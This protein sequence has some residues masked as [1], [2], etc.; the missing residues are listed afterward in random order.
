MFAP[1]LENIVAYFV[2]DFHYKR[3]F[4]FA[5]DWWGA[6]GGE[7]EGAPQTE[8]RLYS[9]QHPQTT[10]VFKKD[11]AL[12]V[13][14]CRT[15][16][17]NFS[18]IASHFCNTH[19]EYDEE[20]IE[21]QFKDTFVMLKILEID[22]NNA[23]QKELSRNIVTYNNSQNSIDEKTFV[24][25]N[26]L[27]QRFKN[28]F[29]SKGFLLLTKQSDKNTF[30]EKYKKKSE[31]F[32]FTTRSIERRQIFGLDSLQKTADFFIPLEKLLQVILAFRLGG[33]AAY[34]QKKDVLKPDTQTYNAVVDFIKSSNVTTDVLLN[35][36]LL[37]MRAEK[38]K[39][40][41]SANPTFKVATPISF[42]LIDGFA[43]YEC[44]GGDVKK[45]NTN[46]ETSNQVLKLMKL[47]TMI[48]HMYSSAF[49]QQKNVDY[50]KMIKM[51]I[52]YILLKQNHDQAEM[53]FNVSQTM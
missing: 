39:T 31:L 13:V 5:T 33:L 22:P 18:E 53:M 48:C 29:E 49:M 23:A 16:C 46:L 28:E 15:L 52:D 30:A 51:E 24:A 43:R 25:N 20:D 50:I 32:K 3:C 8:N 7:F 1:L 9:F 19:K 26:E 37:Y 10:M 45:I 14:I 44:E 17:Y 4:F 36:Y 41:N 47:Y 21:E 34:T 40:S 2:S 6:Y 35:L 11:Y 42:Y 27:F 12:F 38:E